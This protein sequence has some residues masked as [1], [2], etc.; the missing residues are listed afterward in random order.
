M[1]RFED[2]RYRYRDNAPWALDGVSLLVRAGETLALLG[3]NGAG[4]S[5]LLALA[6]GLRQP[7]TGKISFAPGVQTRGGLALVPQD[8]AFYP[9]L[10]CRENLD[11]FAGVIGLSRGAKQ[12]RV[13]AAVQAGGLASVLDR[14]AGECSGGLKRRLNLAI[15]LVGDPRLLLLDEPTVGVDPQSRTYLLD[16]V[17]ALR[18]AGKAI[19]YTTHY[20]E[21][22]QV[23]ADR[24]AVIDHGRILLCAT[25]AELATAGAPTLRV[26]TSP[27]P[28]SRQRDQLKLCTQLLDESDAATG[29]PLIF[30]TSVEC[31]PERV[32]AHLRELGLTV[33]DIRYGA[34]DLEGLFLRL[35]RRALRD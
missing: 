7:V 20:M 2:I 31:P 5:T 18:E 34:H 29:S 16:R 4:K 35:T 32:L 1:L 6:A 15:G 23:I 19:V 9:M 22:A 21:E 30:A 8:F 3:P 13:A 33:A 12:T 10:T 28:D 27:M 25:M 11:F 26:R 14:R 24:V 17:R